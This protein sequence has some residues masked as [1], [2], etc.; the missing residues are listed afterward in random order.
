MVKIPEP[1]P[2]D[3]EREKK[4]KCPTRKSTDSNLPPG[5]VYFAAV[6]CC[7]S[8]PP[9]GDSTASDEKTKT[10]NVPPWSP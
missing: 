5:A 2:V 9:R 8:G 10:P 3:A 7:F 6:R 1:V 4:K